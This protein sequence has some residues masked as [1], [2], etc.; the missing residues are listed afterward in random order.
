MT[1][2]RKHSEA[3]RG[4][5]RGQGRSPTLGPL[6]WN[7]LNAMQL[8]RINHWHQVIYVVDDMTNPMD[9]KTH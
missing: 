4:G 7:S 1:V 8:Q 2:V 6:S 5:G 9:A 3:R